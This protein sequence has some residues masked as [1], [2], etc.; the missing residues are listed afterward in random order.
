MITDDNKVHEVFTPAT[1]DLS[2]KLWREDSSNGQGAGVS[3]NYY[4]DTLLNEG[5]KARERSIKYSRETKAAKQ[6]AQQQERDVN[7]FKL[8]CVMNAAQVFGAGI[9]SFLEFAA[10]YNIKT[11]FALELWKQYEVG[12]SAAKDKQQPQGKAANAA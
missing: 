12:L 4:L 11:A 1:L 7:A 9:S 6:D 10:K 2:T 5:R 3:L 8:A